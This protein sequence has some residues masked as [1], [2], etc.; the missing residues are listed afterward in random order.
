MLLYPSAPPVALP[1]HCKRIWGCVLAIIGLIAYTWEG[2]DESPA[3]CLE[4]RLTMA[5][6]AG[7][8]KCI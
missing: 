8:F 6:E 1:R 5:L 4:T 2:V 7:G 3:V